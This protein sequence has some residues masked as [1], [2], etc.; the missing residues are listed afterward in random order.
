[1]LKHL[2]AWAIRAGALFRR[3]RGEREF[4]EELA[5]HLQLHIDDNLRAGMTPS[6]ARRQALIALGGIEQTKEAHR[7]RRGIPLI[8][9]LGRDLRHG[10]R[11][12]IKTPGFTLPA[13]VI[14]GLGIGVN[15]AVFTMVNAVML[16]PLPFQESDRLMR[17]WHT[18][19][20]LF[21]GQQVFPLSPANFLDWQEQSR[22]FESMAIYGNRPRTLT[23]QGEPDALLTARASA[24]MLPILRMQPII[25]RTF[26][27]DE[28]RAGGE[29]TVILSE[30]TWR[31]RFGAQPSVLGQKIMLDGEPHTVV[32]V[33]PQATAFVS[34]VQL[35]VP[36]AWSDEDRA[37]RENH[38]YLAIARLAPG[39][40]VEQAQADLTTIS[41]RLEQ[42]YPEANKDWGARVL[43]LHEDLVGDVRPSLLVLLGA[44]GLV[45]LIAC[46]NLANL[47][48][49]R[50]H[51]RAKEIA[52]RTALGASRARVMQQLA[53]EGLLL[54]VCGG[55]AGL[56][57]GV[58]GV[59]VLVALFGTQL[60]R[61]ADVT[62]DGSVLVFTLAVSILTGLTA[63][64]A[65]A[66]QF[67]KRDANS[68][69][70]QGAE[71]GSSSGGDGRVRQLLV[72]SEVALALMLLVGAGLL[73]RSMAGLRA[74]DP[75]FDPRSMLTA[76]IDVPEAK[77]PTIVDRVRFFDRVLQNVRALP[78]VVSASSVDTLPLQGGSSQPVAVEGMPIVQQS[79]QPVVAVRI[80][81][82]GYF[83]TADIPFV[84]GR[85]FG[86][87]DGEPNRPLVAI[88]SEQTAARF[89]PGRSPIGQHITLGL[90]SNEPREVV[91]VVGEVRVEQLDGRE[92]EPTI[93]LPTV[94]LGF[95]NTTLVI[96]TAVPPNN[97][98]RAVIG[99]VRAVDAE[100]PVL[101]IMTMDAVVEESLGQRR[102]AMWLL[103]GFAG[104]AL[105]LASIGIYSVLAFAVRQRV[106]EIGIR[107][108]LGAPSTVVV[109]MVMLEGLK[110]T[111]TGV[112]LGLLLAAAL[113]RVLTTLLY[114]VTEHDPGTLGAVA[115][116]VILVG[117][118]AT[119][120][121]AYRAT[122]VDP[123][124]TLRSE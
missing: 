77:Y 8:E 94:Q 87:Q 106:R 111:V 99:A 44:V 92:P 71:R 34:R 104:L 50:T 24:A 97:L 61:V 55:L 115:V 65:P 78:G 89:W 25:G 91:G 13:I 79:E 22:S 58:Y 66:W 36:L 52:V 120:L 110:P 76:T 16:R 1:M 43:P 6:E 64:A 29:R 18:P 70:K 31:N 26:T 5:S 93:Y 88:V 109:R 19:P 15:T 14:L 113:G 105:L 69:L 114:G 48:L 101:D 117:V 124:R 98:T 11:G 45:L 90:M 30:G 62:V 116:V 67:T 95:S 33:A 54:G 10:I 112:V 51:G 20:P 39:V 23:G 103:A 72:V 102:F 21:A 84:N 96:R 41:R 9:T 121:P 27:A 81:A 119:L 37:T 82:P 57:T 100:Q 4:D 118:A 122:R 28:D 73:V 85:D 46:A 68:V 53:V 7:D 86:E 59:R 80:S 49:V 17:L 3:S 42:Q 74:L 32:G 60:P 56:L 63:A 38:N 2:R 47:L 123:V 40:S 12:L 83:N 108:A 35:W 107:M 75:G